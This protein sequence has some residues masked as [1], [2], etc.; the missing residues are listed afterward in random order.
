MTTSESSSQTCHMSLAT[1]EDVVRS[2]RSMDDTHL[3]RG[4]LSTGSVDERQT[5]VWPE[6]YESAH[7]SRVLQELLQARDALRHR[8]ML[9]RTRIFLQIMV[10]P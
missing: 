3:S 4:H 7:T 2:S 8:S 1:A 10:L 5:Y 9:L 6:L